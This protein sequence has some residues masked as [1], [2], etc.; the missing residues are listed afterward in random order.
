MEILYGRCAGLDVHKKNV[1][2]CFAC[3]G[4]GGKRQKET[5]MYLTMTQDLLEM[6]DWLK[7]QGCTHI[8]MEATGVYWKPIYNLLEGDC[9]I[10]VVNAYHIKTVPGRKTDVKDA[11]W[12]AD[13][14]SHGLLTAS[15]IPSAPQRE[16]R[17]LT[18]Y[19]AKRVEERAREVNRLQ[20]T[21][22]DTNLK[23]GD[24]VS[25]VM[26]KAAQMILHAVVDGETDTVRLANF[27]AGR[28]RANRETLER[29]LMG[30]VTAHHRFLLGEH[31]TQI[32][33]LDE[34][35]GRLSEEIARRLTPP[36]PPT[37][38]CEEEEQPASPNA[39][40]PGS[41]PSSVGSPTLLDWQQAVEIIDQITGI[42][43][44]IAE[45]LL[46]EIG[47][48]MGQFPS[49]KHLASWVGICPG[50]HE[51]AG[52]RLSG[53][54]RKGNPYARQLLIQ[55]AHAA[56]HSKNTYLATQYRRIAARRGTKKAAVA[57]GH[58]ILVIIYH[59]LRNGETYRDLGGN[60]FDERDRQVVQKHLVR[61]LERM[62]Y[63]VE[64]QPLA[65]AG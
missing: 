24:V 22:E 27:A 7:E 42:S 34:A 57:V 28:V 54:T 50:N 52:K 61:R 59:L 53:K 14:L 62:G 23:L 64:L 46:A 20:K 45:G 3:P 47:V 35:I 51:S 38:Q 16:L 19:R 37:P 18:R 30:R 49:A 63:Q 48:N 15:F 26:G 5:R 21:L 9:T 44:R 56:S 32:E 39:T 2:A 6:R 13:L 40:K 29:A 65:Q 17:D 31:L 11:E 8:A 55:A 10:L 1:K 43:Q 12:I 33:H 25:D 60:Y 41:P 58:S 4:E 36:E